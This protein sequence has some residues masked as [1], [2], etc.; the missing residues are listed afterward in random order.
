[1]S[2]SNDRGVYFCKTP[3]MDEFNKTLY[4]FL[5]D[6][7]VLDTYK[8]DNWVSTVK[9]NYGQVE[10]LNIPISFDIETSST[11]IGE[12]KF[13]TM[14]IWQF[15][16]N[17]V[18]ILG[19][20]WWQFMLLLNKLVDYYN[21]NLNRRILCYVHNLGYE[22]QFM[23]EWIK[24]QEVFAP[25]K[26][27][28]LIALATNGIEFR[29]SL[30]L[31]NYALA[32]IHLNKYVVN[33]AV[34]DLDYSKLRTS[35]T[36]ITD[37]ELGYCINDVRVVMSYIQEKIELEGSIVAIPLTNTGNVRRF[38]RNRVFGDKFSGR[39]AKRIRRRYNDLMSNLRIRSKDEYDQLKRAFAGG[40]T[41][42]AVQYSRQVLEEEEVGEIGSMDLASSYP[43]VC[44]AEYFPMSGV[45]EEFDSISSFD[46]FKKL[47]SKYCVIFDAKITGLKPI[48]EYENMLSA[49]KCIFSGEHSE[50]NGRVI[51]ADELFTTFTELDFDTFLKF[52]DFDT[53]RVYNVRCY[54]R[55]YL[56]KDLILSILDLYEAKTTLKGVEGSEIDYM[57]SKNMINSCYGMMVTNIVRDELDYDGEWIERKLTDEAA[58][59]QLKDY[60]NDW[61][62]FLFYA[63][64]VYVTAHA[65][66]NLFSAILEF[67]K[68]FVYADTDSIKGLNF[69]DHMKWINNYNEN[70]FLKLVQM[71]MYHGIDFQKCQPKTIKGIKKLIG[72]WE[73]EDSYS[74]FKT[75]GAKRYIYEYKKT[76]K[77]GL[78]CAGVAKKQALEYLLEKNNN[79]NFAAM[80]DFDWGLYLPAGKGGKMS[81]T[82]I[83]KE[84][85]AELVDYLG[86]PYNC[87]EKS[88]VHMEQ[89]SYYLSLTKE[90]LDYIQGI[91]EVSL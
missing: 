38:V 22:F 76:G 4:S 6:A 21:L 15:G 73:I 17:G 80:V 11:Y 47:L 88:F 51:S 3:D 2:Y 9:C 82:Y 61:S 5:A 8:S 16:I 64:G 68:D 32:N 56:P 79:S 37:K 85:S 78:T 33:K 70:V 35:I 86:V 25:K 14:Y 50:N 46:Y 65:R 12:D 45:I 18:I 55:G 89:G 30:L 75:I 81:V 43:Y 28:P 41:H 39:E 42:A 31:S 63:W 58:I 72:V 10:Y 74:K 71:C 36:P 62:R 7:N 67:G 1:M 20:T 44:V 91:R 29:C 49:S 48:F 77:L 52:Y 54:R 57:V 24:W 27:R 34:G 87:Y 83:D 40:F 90:Y 23:R 53:I 66:H 69:K 59:S 13:A 84:V 60:N 26:R 19:R